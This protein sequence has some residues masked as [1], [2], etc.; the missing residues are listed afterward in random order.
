MHE[1]IYDQVV[2]RLRNAY[3]QV[4][5]GDPLD[6]RL[7]LVLSPVQFFL[8][9]H[10]YHHWCNSQLIAQVDFLSKFRYGKP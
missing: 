7:Y 1:K 6:G 8:A 10:A 2:E 4:R 9:K 5:I 3:K